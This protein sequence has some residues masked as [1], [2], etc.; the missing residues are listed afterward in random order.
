[1]CKVIQKC[2]VVFMVSKKQVVSVLISGEESSTKPRGYM[3]YQVCNRMAAL[4][5]LLS[6][7]TGSFT[8]FEHKT[9][10]LVVGCRICSIHSFTMIKVHSQ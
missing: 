3:D 10:I 9:K 7:E 1:M 6:L 2:T 8:V 5:T 4:N